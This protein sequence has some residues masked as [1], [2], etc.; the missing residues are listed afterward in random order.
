MLHRRLFLNR[1]RSTLAAS[2][3]PTAVCS[4]ARRGQFGVPQ[5]T[6]HTQ[7]P[8]GGGDSL[9]G[10]GTAAGFDD[11]GGGGGGGEGPMVMGSH[12]IFETAEAAKVKNLFHDGV[13]HR[14]TLCDE[15]IG[16]WQGHVVFVPHQARL[17]IVER[18]LTGFAGPPEHV[19]E[20]WWGYLQEKREEG[21]HHRIRGMSSAFSEERRKRL[22][23]LLAWLVE[24]RIIRHSLV[25]WDSE[26]KQFSRSG[27][28]ERLE[29]IGDNVVKNVVQDRMHVAFPPEDGGLN[30]KLN[31]IQ[32]LIDSNE[33]L[34]RIFDFLQLDKIIGA[35]LS[36]SKF[37]SDVVECLFGELQTL[38]WACAEP[39]STF[40]TDFDAPDLYAGLPTMRAVLQHA[41]F[42]LTDVVLMWALESTVRNALPIIKKHFNPANL[43]ADGGG[44][45]VAEARLG[46]SRRR[47]GLRGAFRGLNEGALPGRGGGAAGGSPFAKYDIKPFLTDEPAATT[48]GRVVTLR[49]ANVAA[50]EREKALEAFASVGRH[51]D[52][53]RRPRLRG[54]GEG[55]SPTIN[56]LL[57]AA[58]RR[59]KSAA[60]SKDE[61]LPS[62][63]LELAALDHTM[64]HSAVFA[65]PKPPRETDETTVT[66]EDY[67]AQSLMEELETEYRLLCREYRQ[68]ISYVG[69]VFADSTRDL[70]E[71]LIASSRLASAGR[72]ANVLPQLQALPLTDWSLRSTVP[73][74]VVYEQPAQLCVASDFSQM[75]PLLLPR[76]RLPV[77]PDHDASPPVRIDEDQAVVAL[78]PELQA[79]QPTTWELRSEPQADRAYEWLP[80]HLQRLPFRYCVAPAESPPLRHVLMR[81]LADRGQSRADAPWRLEDLPT[82]GALSLARGA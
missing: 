61:A 16:N 20:R 64:R 17:G 31:W 7:Q 70:A 9:I 51:P 63:P 30:S 60:A 68:R 73:A 79:A 62:S 25:V 14:C 10:G 11:F 42:E 22:V 49:G 45:G 71:A 80:R 33:G 8:V 2:Y 26:K 23:Y 48:N 75:R 47:G 78:P 29:M 81:P 50:R 56:L 43:T 6:Y 36:Q 67:A 53:S 58:S 54:S 44:G 69:R 4:G 24:F 46:R 39:T 65:M 5:S 41:L 28:F 72:V 19:V 38:L 32:Q 3:L 52:F 18:V 27:E 12:G 21:T 35:P 40:S 13:F 66:D 37:K 76:V 34:L 59:H 77:R 55:A 15:S 57:A 74:S 1:L 82:D